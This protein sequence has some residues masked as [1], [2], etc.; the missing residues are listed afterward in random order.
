MN[1][2]YVT[3]KEA[4]EMLRVS[5]KTIRRRIQKGE[6][7]AELMNSPYGQQYFIKKD[8]INN[9]LQII[10]V[11]QV[12]KEYDLQELALSLSDYM[13]KRDSALIKTISDLTDEVRKLQEDNSNL[14]Q[15]L[16]S[17]QETRLKSIS[18]QLEDLSNEITLLNNKKGLWGIFGR[19][20][21]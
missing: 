4:A 18:D 21:T 3:V 9:A 19:N 14:Q 6:L 20:K 10:D 5:D 8:Q 13:E 17:E 11:V 12:K 2:E 15:Q 16:K 1:N 7:K